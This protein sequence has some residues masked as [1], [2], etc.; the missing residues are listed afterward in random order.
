MRDE[1]V[2]VLQNVLNELGS[3]GGNKPVNERI[4]ADQ[5]PSQTDEMKELMDEK[6][7]DEPIRE[8]GIAIKSF[9]IVSVTP[10]EN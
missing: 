5:L 3:I 4:G 7:F 10:D 9:V 6:V 1:V 2:G 8:R